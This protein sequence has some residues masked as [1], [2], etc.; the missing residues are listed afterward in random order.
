MNRAK[1]D[2]RREFRVEET[3]S[4]LPDSVRP[5]PRTPGPT[6]FRTVYDDTEIA[7]RLKVPSVT[8]STSSSARSA[9]LILLTLAV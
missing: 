8:C 4:S 1:R 3:E 5:F 6:G 7:C 2:A 9:Q